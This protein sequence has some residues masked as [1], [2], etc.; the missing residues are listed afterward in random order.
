[1]KINE[2]YCPACKSPIKVEGNIILSAETQSGDQGLILLKPELGDYKILKH[3]SFKLRIGE[4]IKFSCP[5][6]KT[7]LKG[8]KEN[9]AEIILIDKSG[10]NYTIQ[11]SEIL[12]EQVTYKIQDGKVKEEFGKNKK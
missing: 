8:E 10:I 2:Y 12:G 1:M 7:G 9:M 4:R 3:H 5:I 6:C 11:F